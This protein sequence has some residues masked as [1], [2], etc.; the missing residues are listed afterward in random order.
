MYSIYIYIYTQY[1]YIYI[2][3]TSLISSF[4]VSM[5]VH[6]NLNAIVS[7]LL[8]NKSLLLLRLPSYQF[9]FYTL[10]VY[11][12]IIYFHPVLLTNKI[13]THSSTLIFHMDDIKTIHRYKYLFITAHPFKNRRTFL[14]NCILEKVIPT[15]LSS[16]LHPSQHIFPDYICLHLET[17]IHDLK[18]S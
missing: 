12:S 8:L 16:V 1:I 4:M 5:M 3:L 10:S 15:S 11:H 17:S 7:T 2:Y 6:K 9:F 14:T 18:F 13:Q